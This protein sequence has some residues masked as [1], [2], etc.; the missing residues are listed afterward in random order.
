MK[1]TT[2]L[3]LIL[4]A[5]PLQARLVTY[6]FHIT[7]K[8]INVTGKSS[9]A[10]AI[11]GQIPGPTIEATVGDILQVTFHNDLNEETSIH[12]HGIL[13]PND[14]DGV[15]YL[16][17]PP[18][19]AHSSFTYRYPIIHHGTYWYHSHTGLQEQRGIYGSLVFHP[20]GGE[21]H[22]TDKEHVVVLSDWT[23]E[24]PRKVIHNIKRDPDFYALKKG[25]VQSWLG[26]LKNGY[27][28]IK[29]RL[30]SSWTRMGPMDLSDIGYDAFLANGVTSSYYDAHPG[31]KVRVRLINASA[32]SYF[33]VEFAGGPMLLIAADGVDVKPIHVK[34]LRM[35]IAETYDLIITIPDSK[36]YELRATSIDGTGYSSL[37]YGS[38]DKV[39]APNIPRPNL[40]LMSHG[41]HDMKKH[42]VPKMDVHEGH[43]MGHMGHTS[44]MNMAPKKLPAIAHMI[45]YKNLRAIKNT[46]FPTSLKRR[47]VILNVTG[48]MERYV[49]SFNNKTLKESDTILI[50]KGEIVRFIF[51]N[52]TMMHHPLHLHGHFFRVINGQGD[53]S[54]LKHT[55]NIQPME[56]LTIEFEANEEKDWFFHCHN[57]YHM[58]S[59]MARVVSY[60]DSTTM[61]KKKLKQL[62]HDNWYMSRDISTLSNMTMG[63]LSFSNTRNI[64]ACEFHWDYKKEYDVEIFYERR[65]HRYLG[66]YLGGNFEREDDPENVAVFGVHYVLPLLIDADFRVD[67]KGKLRLELESALQLSDRGSFEWIWN[68]DK[69]YR[70]ALSYEITKNILLTGAYDSDYKW[71]AG[72]RLKF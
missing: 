53:R 9:E 29:N 37:F 7:K 54:P 39:Y 71:G 60:E 11:G 5:T 68:T 17:T 58:M 20:K 2:L 18:I 56:K 65:L 72:L 35:A 33:N 4:L 64:F 19:A 47:D 14:Q 67:S 6:E 44:H 16:T 15:P 69:E 59:G 30:R 8:C 51:D 12:W 42:E 70:F 36:A 13:L 49:W 57:L 21:L 55:V 40:Y 10:L 3:M 34:R 27:E 32:S 62:D 1:I 22:K 38:G 28:A 46:A 25:S 43:S 63:M 23:D 52:K 31:Q 50:K 24:N 48:N 66:V 61:S 45:N 26:V 41:M